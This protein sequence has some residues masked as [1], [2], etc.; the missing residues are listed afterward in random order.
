MKTLSGTADA[1][2]LGYKCMN[3]KLAH[4]VGSLSERWLDG[5]L[6]S[7]LG[8]AKEIGWDGDQPQEQGSGGRSLLEGQRAGLNVGTHQQLGGN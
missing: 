3:S 2:S 4:P 6:G 5:A 8:G 7:T 1:E